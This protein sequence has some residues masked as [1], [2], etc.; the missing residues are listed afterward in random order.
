MTP[1]VTLETFLIPTI[2]PGRSHPWRPISSDLNPPTLDIS[3]FLLSYI[4]TVVRVIIL[5]FPNLGERNILC[6]GSTCRR[7]VDPGRFTGSA[8]EFL[9]QKL[10]ERKLSKELADSAKSG[11]SL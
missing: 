9:L 11:V 2:T 3:K 5:F 8:Q 1:C 7:E 10:S 6:S 4:R